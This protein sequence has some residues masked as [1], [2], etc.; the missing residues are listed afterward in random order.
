M[1]EQY[2]RSL[3]AFPIKVFSFMGFW[4]PIGFGANASAQEQPKPDESSKTEEVLEDNQYDWQNS[5]PVDISAIRFVPGKGLRI[6]SRDKNFALETRL[7]IQYR[8]DVN[9]SEE[10]FSDDE[11][12]IQIAAMLRRARLQF[13]GNLWGPKT[14]FKAEFAMAPRDLGM[15]GSDNPPIVNGDQRVSRSPLLD[16]YIQFEQLR[17]LTVRMGQYKVPYSRERV[18]SSGDLQFV[19]RTILNREFTVDRDIG[20]DIRSSDLF[21][22]DKRLRYAIGIYAGE[23]HSS[24]QSNDL[25]LMSLARLEY[26]PFGDFKDYKQSDLSRTEFTGLSFGLGV[27][28]VQ[29]GKGSRG[30][31]GRRFADEGTTDYDN[32]NFDIAFKKQGYSLD[33]VYFRRYGTRNP[34]SA[35]DDNGGLIAV[36]EARNGWGYGAQGGYLFAND[37]EVATRYSKIVGSEGT[38][39]LQDV[40]EAGIG[41]SYYLASHLFKWQADYLK[42]WGEG[43]NDSGA[44]FD[45]ARDQLRVQ[46]QIAF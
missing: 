39:S 7:R 20:F 4:L 28:R 6:E 21:G 41:V 3:K 12:R 25:N 44:D 32:L 13:T 19:D 34:G 23:G 14:K 18:I 26:L 16:W 31:I 30:I 29:G 22:L 1:F 9:Q 2:A 11:D 43:D 27:A 36:T 24:Y 17:D 10:D 15:T 37:M 40:E 8:I 45:D 5:H 35:T 42:F 46:M 38:T 33:A